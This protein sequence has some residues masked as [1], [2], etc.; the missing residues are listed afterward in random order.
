VRAQ[1]RIAVV[2]LDDPGTRLTRAFRDR[3]GADVTW[4]CDRRREVRKAIGERFP[5]IRVSGRV[6]DVL[7]DE[8]VDAVVIAT[9]PS[10]HFELVRRTL[11]AGKHVFVTKPLALREAHAQAL[12]ALAGRKRRGLMVE[13]LFLFHP[14]V[15]KLKELIELGHL[16]DVYYAEVGR[17]ELTRE[18]TDVGTLWRLGAHDIAVVLYLLGQAPELVSA[19]GESHSPDG[20]HDVIQCRLDFPNDLM[21]HVRLSRL[22]PRQIR[23]LA[24]VGSERTAVVDP[25]APA[26]LTLHER[27]AAISRRASEARL[28][29]VVGIQFPDERPLE[30]ACDHFLAVTRSTRQAR[31]GRDDAARAVSVLSALARS[32]ARGGQPEPLERGDEGAAN[33]AVVPLVR[34]AGRWSK[35]A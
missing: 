11:D 27:G 2:G 18:D 33:T 20:A 10:T 24:V 15:R 16:G 8:T 29:D 21:A 6:S 12:V 7:T 23:R 22:D 31:D 14:A 26:A 3:P 32:L 4:L 34:D 13:H 1:V 30:L 25:S 5:E 28:G 35:G 17:Q 9:P 19:Q